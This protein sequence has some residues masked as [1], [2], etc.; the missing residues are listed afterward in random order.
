MAVGKDLARDLAPPR[1]R[2][3]GPRPAA[4]RP[5]AGHTLE[6]C[7]LPACWG[8]RPRSAR[9][10]TRRAPTRRREEGD[11]HHPRGCLASSRP[12]FGFRRSPRSRRLGGAI[13]KS[14]PP[15]SILVVP[16]H[17]NQ[18]TA[19]KELERDPIG[20]TVDQKSERRPYE[21][22]SIVWREDLEPVLFGVCCGK[23]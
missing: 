13:P 8:N 14:G 1:G 10:S 16:R 3:H 18:E 9:Q 17:T 15:A 19:M 21:P 7:S 23:G 12:P 6:G 20:S 22:H 11:R 5:P 2:K 4:R